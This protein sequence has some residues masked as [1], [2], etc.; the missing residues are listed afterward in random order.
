VENFQSSKNNSVGNGENNPVLC[1]W[2]EIVADRGAE[3]AVLACDGGALRTFDEVESESREMAE[4]FLEVPPGRI[5]SCQIGNSPA[6]PAFILAA[7]R[8]GCGVLLLDKDHT[9]ARRERLEEL[10]GAV[11]RLE[12][13]GIVR[14]GG[15]ISDLES[16]VAA[17]LL[18]VT[19][20]S[21]GE[22]RTIRFSAAQLLADADAIC[23]TM[24]LG[25]TDINYGAIAFS[26]SYGFS[27][28]ITPLLGRGISLVAAGDMMPRAVVDGLLASRATVFAGVPAL[29]RLLGELTPPDLAL[30]LCISAGA[31]LTPEIAEGFH[32]T[33]GRKIHSFYGASECGGMCYDTTEE[34]VPPRGFV[35]TPLRGVTLERQEDG[36][37]TIRSAAVGLGYFPPGMDDPLQGGVF[38]PSDLLEWNGAGYVIKGRVSDVINVGG[39]KVNPAE[40]E[41][42]IQ[43]LPGVR[44]VVVLSLSSHLRGEEVAACVAGEVAED[45]LRQHCGQHL[46]AWQVPR[47]WFIWVEIPVNSRGKISRADLRTRL[48]ESQAR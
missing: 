30:R 4:Y 26:H 1:R 42:V 19:S 38:A 16:P 10:S 21:T 15:G 31:P 3:I 35:G 12:P 39:R 13:S 43:K 11:F 28:L 5:V 44:E 22:P 32:R 45:L 7:W 29:F 9:P 40:I 24:G 41:R 2:A 18:K 14:L 47:H 33:W 36:S 46:P 17:D 6:F 37:I 20:G 34:P 27:N 48:L 25:E 23:E 8:A